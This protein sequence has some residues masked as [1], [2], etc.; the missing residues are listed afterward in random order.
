VARGRRIG[1]RS[2]PRTYLWR[3]EDADRDMI[4]VTFVQ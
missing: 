1:A 4:R 3:M 2:A